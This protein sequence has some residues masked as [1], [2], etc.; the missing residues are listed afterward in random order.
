MSGLD[1]FSNA[2][3]SRELEARRKRRTD[4]EY[5]E[6]CKKF[7][8]PECGGNPSEISTNAVEEHRFAPRDDEGRPMLYMPYEAGFT[9]GLT[10]QM[11]VTCENG[12]TW[13]PDP[14][15]KWFD[16]P[17]EGPPILPRPR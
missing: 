3:L 7:P 6:L 5:A 2:E 1:K 16:K 8:C 13:Y 12:H 4:E 11:K 17:H 9:G 15:T 14:V 10:Y